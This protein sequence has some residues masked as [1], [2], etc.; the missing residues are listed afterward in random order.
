MVNSARLR[1]FGV[2]VGTFVWDS[3][4]NL[5]RFEYDRSGGQL[6]AQSARLNEI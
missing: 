4:Y 3:R 2:N 5:A 6:I 1:M